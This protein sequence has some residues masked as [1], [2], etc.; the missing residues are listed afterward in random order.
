MKKL[1]LGLVLGFFLTKGL[2]VFADY[3]WISRENA[4][5]KRNTDIMKCNTSSEKTW[6]EKVAYSNVNI[7]CFVADKDIKFI[8]CN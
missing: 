3:L 8:F 7:A 5:H 4:C 1:L 2:N 6:I